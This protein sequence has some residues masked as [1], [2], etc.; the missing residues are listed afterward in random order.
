MQGQSDCFL[1]QFAEFH[2]FN[3]SHAR[4]QL[5]PYLSQCSCENYHIKLFAGRMLYSENHE[6]LDV[7]DNRAK[8]GITDHAQVSF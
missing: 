7:Q 6:Y 2:F 5:K 3:L 1:V 8:V 4:L